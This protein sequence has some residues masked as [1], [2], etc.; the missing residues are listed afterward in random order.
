[1]P[2][3]E[4]NIY[5]L[6][7][8]K[9]TAKAAAPVVANARAMIQ[10]AGDFSTNRE[11]GSE[12]WSDLA[13]FGNQT[14][15]VNTIVGGGNPGIEFQPAPGGYVCWNFF[16][17]ETVTGA[18]DPWTHNFQP[19]SGGGFYSTWYARVGAG[20]APTKRERHTDARIA[21][22]TVEGSTGQ[23]VVRL[24]PTV[25]TLDPGIIYTT[26]P[27]GTNATILTAA[28]SIPFNY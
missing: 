1:M 19:T 17:G 10:V 28:G 13:R 6:W 9:Q 2:V 22:L 7:V 3:L 20:A 8:V 11:D 18:A 5:G 4:S 27:A 23:K 26:D 25:I 15:F 12:V 24:T 16:G 14:D 21:A